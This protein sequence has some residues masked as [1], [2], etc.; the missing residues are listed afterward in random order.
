MGGNHTAMLERAGCDAGQAV[1]RVR[2][3]ARP[4]AACP[5]AQQ[6]ISALILSTCFLEWQTFSQGIPSLSRSAPE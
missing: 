1:T 5:I 4:A 3:K 6:P 2:T